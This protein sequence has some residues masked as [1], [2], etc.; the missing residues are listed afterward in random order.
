MEHWRPMLRMGLGLPYAE[1]LEM[2]IP[3]LV[4]HVD[5]WLD[6]RPGGEQ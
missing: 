4:D 2:S 5:W 3:D 1:V 6:N